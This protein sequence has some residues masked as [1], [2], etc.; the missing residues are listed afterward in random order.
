MNQLVTLE[1]AMVNNVQ[2]PTTTSRKVA[3]FFEKE[4]SNVLKAID[5]LECSE[6]FRK[7]NFN[8]TNYLDVQGKNKREVVLTKDGFVFAVMGF[9]GKKASQFKEAYIK[10]F[11]KMEA[12]L[13]IRSQLTVPQAL[14]ALAITSIEIQGEVKTL[15]ERVTALETTPTTPTAKTTQ[16]KETSKID[17][18]E[19]AET[20]L[21]TYKGTDKFLNSVKGHMEK[22]G[23]ITSRQSYVVNSIA[24][25]LGGK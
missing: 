14:Q 25:K 24:R 19:K 22:R 15:K 20:F 23:K 12:D 5:N 9:T 10:A 4:H 18:I 17:Y 11:N 21:K 2:Q 7:V 3:E 8:S 6:I 1:L 13:S 16:T